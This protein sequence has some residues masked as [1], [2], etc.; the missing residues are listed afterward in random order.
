MNVPPWPAVV[1]RPRQPAG[2][3][4]HP[5]RRCPKDWPPPRC[6]GAPC[7]YT[8]RRT[9][10]RRCPQFA[11]RT[12][13]VRQWLRR[14]AERRTSRLARPARGCKVRIRDRRSQHRDGRGRIY[15][16]GPAWQWRLRCRPGWPSNSNCR[17]WESNPCRR[18][19]GEDVVG[20]TAAVGISQI[21]RRTGRIVEPHRGDGGSRPISSQGN[22]RRRRAARA[23]DEDVSA[24]PLLLESLR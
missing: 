15:V 23:I 14:P 21:E 11:A 12:P 3:S 13:P 17:R 24:A 10:K 9:L 22:P 6:C 19:I 18:H 7:Q 5:R 2:R 20:E 16:T 8:R 1:Q 4:R